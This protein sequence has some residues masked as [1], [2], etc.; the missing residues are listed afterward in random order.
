M[1]NNIKFRKLTPVRS[2]T[3]KKYTNYR[4]YKEYLRKDFNARCGYTDCPDTWFGGQKCFHIDHFKPKSKFQHLENDYSNLVYSCSYVNILKT[5]DI[6]NMID[7]C[8]EEFDQAFY[9]DKHGY[10]CPNPL[11]SN[12][13]V[14]HKKLKLGLERYRIV[15]ILELLKDSLQ[16]LSEVV[17]N[18]ESSISDQEARE[19]M[20]L[21]AE[22]NREFFKYFDYL[23]HK[24]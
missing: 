21:L 22:L 19:N 13:L 3:G 4:S 7:P 17:I 8:S 20:K 1:Q 23:G 10:I 6:D 9:R 12:A 16:N 5:D 24:L 14:M 11:N 18:A 2:Y 15:W